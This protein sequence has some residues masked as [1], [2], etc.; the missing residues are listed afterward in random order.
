MLVLEPPSR[1]GPSIP[2]AT[3]FLRDIEK[4][5]WGRIATW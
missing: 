4:D 5:L 3:V 2:M 1:L